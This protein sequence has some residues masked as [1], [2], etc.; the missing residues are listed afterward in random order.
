MWIRV[1]V[2]GVV[3]GLLVFCTGAFEHMVLGWSGRT[4][5]HLPSETAAVEFVRG[6][7]L[8]PGI[9]GFPDH[10]AN[11]EEL[12]AEEQERVMK[13]LEER[14]QAGPTGWIIIGPSGQDMMGAAQFGGEIAS[15]IAGALIA[16]WIVSLIVPRSFA[17]RWA[18]VAL[19]GVFAWLSISASH[20][21][22]YRFPGLWVGDELFA[23]LLEWSVAGLV[24][25]A[26]VRP[27]GG[28]STDAGEGHADRQ[29]PV[30]AAAV[31]TK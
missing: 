7:Q 6:Q 13:D 25:A 27:C 3:A 9:Y 4:M 5:S 30:S 17:V 31:G 19:M 24:I 11:L 16:A 10:P 21:I 15:N 18:A 22:W 2:A 26:I 23:A 20:Y 8:E 14:Y 1:S 28:C 12:P 29:T